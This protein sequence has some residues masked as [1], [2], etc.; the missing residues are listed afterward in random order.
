V[1]PGSANGVHH[2]HIPAAGTPETKDPA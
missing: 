1:W 2:E